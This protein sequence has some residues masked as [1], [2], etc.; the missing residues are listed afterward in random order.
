MT[1]IKETY[2][3]YVNLGYFICS[4]LILLYCGLIDHF[5]RFLFNKPLKQQA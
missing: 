4:G 3:F 1:I 2:D 5:L